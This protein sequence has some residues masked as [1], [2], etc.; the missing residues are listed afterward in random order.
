[1]VYDD[2]VSSNITQ[3]PGLEHGS[4]QDHE[5]T[6]AA[7]DSDHDLNQSQPLDPDMTAYQHDPFNR[8]VQVDSLKE[9]QAVLETLK[10]IISDAMAQTTEAQYYTTEWFIESSTKAS[11]WH[12]ELW[13]MTVRDNEEGFS[14]SGWELSLYRQTQLISLLHDIPS[15]DMNQVLTGDIW[16]IIETYDTMTGM[17]GGQL[18]NRLVSKALYG[19]KQINQHKTKEDA[20]T[21]ASSMFSASGPYQ[22]WAANMGKHKNQ[23]MY[24]TE[25]A[26]YEDVAGKRW[27]QFW[28]TGG[29]FT[30][31]RVFI[32]G[33]SL[34][35][36]YSAS[37]E[38]FKKLMIELFGLSEDPDNSQSNIVVEFFDDQYE[39]EQ[40]AV[41]SLMGVFKKLAES[42]SRDIRYMHFQ[43]ARLSV[44]QGEVSHRRT[45]TTLFQ[46]T[47]CDFGR[48]CAIGPRSTRRRST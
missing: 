19:L 11:V 30:P 47:N 25:I 12:R 9:N 3:D 42:I 6:E 4:P 22:A 13:L 34:K 38:E 16:N 46:K 29:R 35:L 24:L 32:M 44:S 28:T 5:M 27:H 37:K 41:K 1:M 10:K 23:E 39:E 14:S 45:F 21:I 48:R 15:H 43:Q 26:S 20:L 31:R 2:E 8:H 40:A 36:C 7:R 18:E 33:T 17:L